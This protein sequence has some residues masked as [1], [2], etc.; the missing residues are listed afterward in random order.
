MIFSVKRVIA[1]HSCKGG[2]GKSTIAAS[3]GL[4]LASKDFKIGLCDLDI[5]G[6]SL[7]E[8]LSVDK[9]PVCWSS[10][11]GVEKSARIEYDA[12]TDDMDIFSTTDTT[13]CECNI[14]SKSKNVQDTTKIDMPS[15][16]CS[17]EEST[18]MASDSTNGSGI[19]LLEPKTVYGMRIMSS[20]FLLSKGNPGYSAYRGPIIDQLCYEMVYRTNWGNLDFLVLDLPPGTSDVIISLVE[21][22]TISGAIIVTTPHVLS[23][24]DVIRGLRLFRDLDIPILSM[25]ENMSF[26]K[27]D[28]CSSEK[29]I[30]GKSKVEAIC[31]ENMI[32]N[33]VKIPLIGTPDLEK[34][35]D[36]P[37]DPVTT[38]AT[39]TPSLKNIQMINDYHDYASVQKAFDK[40]VDHLKNTASFIYKTNYQLNRK[41]L[42]DPNLSCSG[43]FDW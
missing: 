2:V 19:Q 35:A 14:D 37:M 17:H 25:V 7:S 28:S 4:H 34:V 1:I 6:P 31:K 32:D 40:I 11:K 24:N 38:N 16:E 30:F 13:K 5:C 43:G 21:N 26:Y 29:Y 27:C 3:L 23:Y 10:H 33:F 9:T 8:L 15:C 36:E 22:I 41:N 42:T 20:E 39:Y 18:Q 12:N